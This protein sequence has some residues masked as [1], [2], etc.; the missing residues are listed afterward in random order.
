MQLLSVVGVQ[1]AVYCPA[2]HEN[3]VQAEQEADCVPA[4]LNVPAAH[5]TQATSLIAMQGRRRCPAEHV[6][7]D[8]QFAQ[9]EALVELVEIKVP[10]TQTAQAASLVAVPAWKE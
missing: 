7:A 4:V 5:V 3:A 9:L 10:Y 8:E 2:I 6:G 1:G